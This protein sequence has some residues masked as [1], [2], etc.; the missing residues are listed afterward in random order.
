MMSKRKF[1]AFI[2]AIVIIVIGGIILSVQKGGE[3]RAPG[4]PVSVE[5]LSGILPIDFKDWQNPEEPWQSAPLEESEIP[6]EAIRIGVTAE[7][8]SPSSFEVKK[9]EEVVLAVTSQD[10]W[11]HVF[12]FKDSSLDKVAVGLNP[13]ETKVITFYAPSKVGEYEFFCDV[14]GHERRGEKGKMI[15][16]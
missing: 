14:P 12:R 1:I 6:K 13:G 5:E 2:V 9:G 11:V 16:K 3:E 10:K 8:F 4:E 15:V 7:G